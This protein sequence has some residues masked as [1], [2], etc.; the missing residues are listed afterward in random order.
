MKSY[1]EYKLILKDHTFDEKEELV[2]RILK[3]LRKYHKGDYELK[4][5][6]SMYSRD[7]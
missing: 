5:I 6:A 2:N 7:K 1:N 4:L 3:V